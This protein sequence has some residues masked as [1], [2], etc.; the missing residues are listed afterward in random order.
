MYTW[1]YRDKT[2]GKK[3]SFKPWNESADDICDELMKFLVL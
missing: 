1:R 3:R 2:D